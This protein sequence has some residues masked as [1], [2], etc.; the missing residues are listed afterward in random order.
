MFSL[1]VAVKY[2]LTSFWPRI[3]AFLKMVGL[4]NFFLTKSFVIQLL[5][6]RKKIYHQISVLMTF[7]EFWNNIFKNY[8]I[9]LQFS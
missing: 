8:P 7:L 2:Q 6:K 1:R 4:S 5:H 9:L 3:I